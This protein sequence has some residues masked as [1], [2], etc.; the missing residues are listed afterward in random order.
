M[1]KLIIIEGTDCSGKQTQANLLLKN[2]KKAGKKAVAFQ[3]PRYDTATGKIVGGPYLGKRDI[4]EGFFS[5]GAPNVPAK[6]A[7]LYFLA[8]R[9]Y[10]APEL[11]NFLN[12]GYTVIL[13][14]YVE[15]NMAFQGGKILN[16]KQRHEMF[17]FLHNLEYNLYNLPKPDI[18]LFLHMPYDYACILKQQRDEAPDQHEQDKAILINAENAYKEIAQ[19]YNFKTISCVKD[20]KIKTTNQIENEVL[21][22]VVSQLN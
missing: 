11:Q 16:K 5:E 2:L 21:D 8:D 13:D 10:N 3:F 1:G 19:F 6:V 22:Y 12:Q 17:E 9:A 18:K 7:S 20:G 15:S 14:R 4:G